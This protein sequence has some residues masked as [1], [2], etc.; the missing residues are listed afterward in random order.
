MPLTRKIGGI[1]LFFFVCLSLSPG[2]LYAQVINGSF[3][4]GGQ[5][6]L[7]AWTFTCDE[8]QPVSSAPPSGGEWSVKLGPGNLQSCSPGL[9]VQKISGVQHEEVWQLSAWARRDATN[10]TIARMYFRIVEASGA[11][12]VLSADTTTSTEWTQ[13]TVT[14]TLHLGPGD[15]VQVVLDA[16]VTSGPTIL[17]SG[18]DFDLIEMVRKPEAVSNDANPQGSAALSP[19]YP[20]PFRDQTAVLFVVDRPSVVR[21]EVYDVL[22]RRVEVLFHGRLPA[23]N[24]RAT[25]IA[26]QAPPGTYVVR[27][28]TD[29][30]RDTQKLVRIP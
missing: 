6:S 8:G 3:E 10:P 9:A 11:E 25:W 23:G 18:F 16:G 26:A 5:P 14:D 19:G 2:L 21:L 13:L 4:E 29:K 27:L 22:G 24:H 12:R 30:G 17:N 28:Q 15:S 7:E 20:N 1:P